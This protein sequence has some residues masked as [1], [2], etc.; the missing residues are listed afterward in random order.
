MIT[1]APEYWRPHDVVE[2]EPAADNVVRSS[3]NCLVMAGPGAG[4]TELLAQRACFLL[5]T[6]AC[7]NPKRI[8]ALSFKRDAAKNLRERVEKRCGEH[9]NRFDSMT[10]DAFGKSLV[11]RFRCGIPPEWRPK[12]GYEVMVN[13]PNINN[14]REWFISTPPPGNGRKYQFETMENDKLKAGF[15]MS[16]Y[17]YQLPYDD[18]SIVPHRKYYGEMWWKERLQCSSDQPSLMFP[19]LN[20]L[21]AYMLRCNPLLKR[22]LTE[23]YSHVFLDEFQ[24]TTSSQYDLI[25]TAF[26]ES[27]CILTAVGDSKQRIMLW[28]GAMRNIFEL[29]AND[30]G[31]DKKSLV[32]NYRSATELVLIQQAIASS[33]DSGSPFVESARSSSSGGVSY[34]AEFRSPEQEANYIADIIQDGISDNQLNPRSFCILARQSP[35]RMT[36][37]LKERLFERGIKL[38]DESELQDLLAEP[39]CNFVLPVLRLAT[40]VRD[41]E[42]WDM[43]NQGLTLIDH[44]DPLD[45]VHETQNEAADIVRCVRQHIDSSDF[46]IDELPSFIANRIGADRLRGVYRQY[47]N[48]TFMNGRLALMGKYLA[49]SRAKTLYGAIDDFLGT[50]VVPA[51]TV[52]KSK[53][54]EFHTVIFL[55]LED[56]QL[57]NFS[58]QTDEEKC[59][60]FVAFSR[61]ISRVIF[62]YSDVRDDRFGR[63]PQT[64]ETIRS[65]YDSRP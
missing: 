61:A 45:E 9:A 28:A 3:Q 63:R 19:M 34:I 52:H 22:A 49:E 38:R 5:E 26:I 37:I 1:V 10:I 44:I 21:A 13:L 12:S 39:I 14:I 17:G 54:L 25:Q 55:G 29:F 16:V 18:S 41:S 31:A 48:A 36:S 24:D 40:C 42:A 62:T 59:G 56:S 51:M 43:L 15:E 6:G 35:G 50:D 60:F 8:L 64:R 46:R 4:K 23:T 7:R 33:I 65:L 32:R 2:L 11:D 27:D 20:R 57:W 58:N 53:G 47:S 30:F